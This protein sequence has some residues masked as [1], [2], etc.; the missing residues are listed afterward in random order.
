M[1]KSLEI[2][3]VSYAMAT[4]AARRQSLVAQNMANADT[5][6]Y[7]PRDLPKFQD[8]VSTSS[9][10]N[11]MRRS[12][13]GHFEATAPADNFRTLS[14]PNQTSPNGNAVSLEEEMMKA[15]N[16]KLQNDRALAIYKSSLNVLRASLG[17]V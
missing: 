15:V 17:R 13:A 8:V 10:A 7:V 9:A 5:P 16:I 6:G 11:S 12:R 14:E 3:Q 1:F 4:H 2:F